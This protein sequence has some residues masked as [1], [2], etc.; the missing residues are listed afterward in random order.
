MR[1]AAAFLLAALFLLAPLPAEQRFEL[2][3]GN[4]L[5]VH[6]DGS[7]EVVNPAAE[8]VSLA[9]KRFDLDYDAT[10]RA[11]LPM[12]YA[13]SPELAILGDDLV[14]SLVETMVGEQLPP[15]SV[16]FVDESTCVAY[17]DG[18]TVTV[19][20][21]VAADG[22]IT[23]TGDDGAEKKFGTLATDGGSITCEDEALADIPLVVFTLAE[24]QS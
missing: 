1:R 24:T 6:D 21:E 14:M 9:G 15:V 8:D 10:I 4:I 11:M 3:D 5:I 13:E 17:L 18:E 22:E 7:T 19:E 16:I 20:Y 2:A 23:I 12:L